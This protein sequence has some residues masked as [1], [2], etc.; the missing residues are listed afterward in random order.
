MTTVSA[1]ALKTK[2]LLILHLRHDIRSQKRI[3]CRHNLDAIISIS[4]L[5]NIYM[6]VCIYIYIDRYRYQRS[7]E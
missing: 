2:A 1:Y 3:G 7:Y 6:Y 4:P 5:Y